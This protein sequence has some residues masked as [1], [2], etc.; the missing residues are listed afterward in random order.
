MR[1]WGKIP[2]LWRCVFF[3]SAQ[4][5]TASRQN[6]FDYDERVSG[7]IIYTY[8]NGNPVSYTDPSGRCPQC[9]AIGGGFIVGAGAYAIGTYIGGGDFSLRDMG[10]AGL[11]GSLAVA[12]AG[13]AV[14]GSLVIGTGKAI[15]GIIGDLGFDLGFHSY[16]AAGVISP[17]SNPPN[18]GAACP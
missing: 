11:G 13:E 4:T 3:D 12:T 7:S 16:D 8:V 5:V 9:I 1:L 18:S 17:V 14:A 10:V 15:L 6:A 2:N